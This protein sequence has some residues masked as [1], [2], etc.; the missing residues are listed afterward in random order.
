[1]TRLNLMAYTNHSKSVVRNSVG[2]TPDNKAELF[3]KSLFYNQK[4]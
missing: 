2:K 1:M 4:F 3:D